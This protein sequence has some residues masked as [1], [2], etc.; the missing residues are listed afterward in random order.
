MLDRQPRSIG[1][2]MSAELWRG[3][4]K[5]RQLTLKYTRC[6]SG[7]EDSAGAGVPGGEGPATAAFVSVTSAGDMVFKVI[8]GG[9]LVTFRTWRET[10][11]HLES[12]PL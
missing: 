5:W 9:R 3:R 11:A 8:G 4:E 1:V 12:L 6:G 2:L 10:S 7:P